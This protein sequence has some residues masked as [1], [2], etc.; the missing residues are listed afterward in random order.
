MVPQLVSLALSG[1]L[2][3]F[4]LTQLYSSPRKAK[5]EVT[6]EHL[7]PES[8]GVEPVVLVRALGHGRRAGEPRIRQVPGSPSDSIL[9]SLA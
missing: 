1:I 3:F 9:F 6:F 2:S 7:T 8:L 5:A 4:L